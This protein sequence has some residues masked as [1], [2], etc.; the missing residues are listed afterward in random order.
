MET[1]LLMALVVVVL[2]IAAAS[3]VRLIDGPQ[4]WIIQLRQRFIFGIPVGSIITI[5]LVLGVYLFLQG[6]LFDWDHP[7]VYPFRA[8]SFLYPQGILSAGVAHSS[9]SHIISNLTATLVLAPLAEY[10]WGHYPQGDGGRSISRDA[11]WTQYPIIRAAVIFPAVALVIALTTGVFG[12]GAVI[13]FSGVVFA[14]GGFAV[15]YYPIATVVGLLSISVI[16]T[17]LDA[18]TDPIAIAT[19]SPGLPSPP[20]WATVSVQ[21]HAMGFLIG[22]ILGLL[23]LYHRNHRPPIARLFLALVIY[24]LTRGLWIVF[25][26]AG[27]GSYVLLRAVGVVL[28]VGGAI[29]VTAAAAASTTS[30]PV[31]DAT[32]KKQRVALLSVVIILALIAGPGLAFNLTSVESTGEYGNDQLAVEDY[33]ISYDENAENQLRPIID[34]PGSETLVGSGSGVIIESEQR[35]IWT[36]AVSQQRLA[37]TGQARVDVGGAGWR[38]TIEIEREG[39]RVTGNGTVYTVTLD[40]DEES[41]LAYRSESRTADAR[42]GNHT[43]TINTT[44]DGSFV[45]QV[46]HQGTT[47][48]TVPLP[49]PGET[50]SVGELTLRGDETNDRTRVLA[51]QDGSSI[52]IAISE[53]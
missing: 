37:A 45:V 47:I 17:L 33:L 34:L 50:I 5:S 51:E 15:M 21:G 43:M 40:H 32:R 35:H 20:S 39:M 24:G 1:Y 16:R 38:E 12:I 46:D 23:L 30:I 27:D 18:L 44:T 42:I 6:G 31:S 25:Y 8:W 3:L 28:V 48:D 19:V 52:Q 13:G 7:V 36:V 9:P 29:V 53:R 2:V 41:V 14:F 11:H 22:V 49:E 4:D 26:Y 10:I